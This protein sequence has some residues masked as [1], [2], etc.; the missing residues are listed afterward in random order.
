MEVVELYA[1]SVYGV[2]QALLHQLQL[3]RL[4][5]V[6]FLLVPLQP[7]MEYFKEN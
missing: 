7:Y 4:M 3:Q 2:I 1:E 5:Q 6:H